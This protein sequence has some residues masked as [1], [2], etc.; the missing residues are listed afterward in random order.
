[1]PVSL[2][3]RKDGSIVVTQALLERAGLA[4]LPRVWAQLG[5]GGIVLR[6]KPE[7]AGLEGGRP[8]RDDE[9]LD[10]GAKGYKF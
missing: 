4:H 5:A 6:A 7:E 2:P 10:D 8:Y 9:E 3:L 1:M